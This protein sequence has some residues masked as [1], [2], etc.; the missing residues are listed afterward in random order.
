MI[1]WHKITFVGDS[2]VLLPAGLVIFIWLLAGRAWRMAFWWAFLYGAGL[3]LV[4]ATKIAFIGWGMGIASLD[5][6]GLSGHAMRASAVFPVLGWLFLQRSTPARRRLG[7][8]AATGIGVLIAVSRVVVHAHSISEAVL[9]WA[10]GSAV[11]AIFIALSSHL[12]APTINRWL[13]AF[14]LM[15]LLPTSYAEPAPTNQWMNSVA[16]YLSGHDRP[17]VRGPNGTFV[18]ADPDW[19]WRAYRHRPK[20]RAD[21]RQRSGP[22]PAWLRGPAGLS[23]AQK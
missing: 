21:K 5:F 11:E 1:P 2:V 4:V 7:M 3:T 19:R 15:G 10:T 13:I 18:L 6:T 16:L 20:A 8:L 12:P 22:D 9:G 17:Y 23:V 14:A